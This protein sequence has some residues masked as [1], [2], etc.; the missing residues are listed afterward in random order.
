M[1]IS[2]ICLTGLGDY[3]RGVTENIILK[4]NKVHIISENEALEKS[5]KL[6]NNDDFNRL[7]LGKLI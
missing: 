6:L 4:D 1:S 7:K 3:G 2:L 5:V